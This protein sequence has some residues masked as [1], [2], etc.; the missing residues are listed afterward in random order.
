M[1]FTNN[2]GQPNKKKNECKCL[3]VE[4]LNVLQNPF[5]GTFFIN[6]NPLKQNINNFSDNSKTELFT[7]IILC[8]EP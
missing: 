3:P 8:W 1:G 5:N 7:S 6:P 4:D 2:P